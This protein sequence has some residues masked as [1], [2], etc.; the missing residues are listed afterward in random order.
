MQRRECLRPGRST[1][2]CITA[3]RQV[4]S[5]GS[6]G[7]DA[8]CNQQANKLEHQFLTIGWYCF[9]VPSWCHD[10]SA[11]AGH[12]AEERRTTMSERVNGPSSTL[13]GLVFEAFYVPTYG[14]TWFTNKD[15]RAAGLMRHMFKSKS[16]TWLMRHMDTVR[17]MSCEDLIA[18]EKK[19]CQAGDVLSNA[20]DRWL[21]ES[22]GRMPLV[23]K[24]YGYCLRR[25][26]HRS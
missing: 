10:R 6:I 4:E 18:F 5:M 8:L 22:H 2:V 17:L 16:D 12:R 1:H 7:F 25:V 9:A 13:S 20:H 23:L 3:W 26:T 14:K 11:S 21:T 19:N 15:G 24:E